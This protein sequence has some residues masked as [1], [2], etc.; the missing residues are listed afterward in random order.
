MEDFAL[1]AHTGETV[2][3]SDLLGEVV[4]VFF[5][6]ASCPDVC[7]ATMSEVSRAVTALGEDAEHVRVLF[8]TVDPERDT[9]KAL[10]DW[11][12][13]WSA[14]ILALRGSQEEI[15]AVER[16]FGAFHQVRRENGDAQIDHS[17]RLWIV[18][19]EG[20]LRLS[21]AA[22]FR[23]EDLAADLRRLLDEAPSG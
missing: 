6:F 8:V 19:P 17:S 2:R 9:R 23:A 10:A 4:L 7:P 22:G 13:H 14:P 1:A 15:T 3:L 18:G 21:H 20:R 12:E 11:A 16:R 5:G